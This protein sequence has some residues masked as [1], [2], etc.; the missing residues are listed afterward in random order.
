MEIIQAL[1]ED[2]PSVKEITQTTIRT[3]YPL[4]YPPGAVAFFSEHHSDERIRKD[5][6][7]GI[8]YLLRKEDGYGGTVT[9]S[10]NEILRL[11]VLP[12]YQGKGYGRALLDFAEQMILRKYDH[13]VIDASLPAKRI[14]IKRGYHET[15]YHMIRTENGEYLCYDVMELRK[16]ALSE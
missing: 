8:V 4:Y 11:F 7:R 16:K 1:P 9:V 15:E 10:G 6:G 3:V 2:F 14:Y 13:V 5:I 12:A